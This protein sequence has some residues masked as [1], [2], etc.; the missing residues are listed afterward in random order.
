MRYSCFGVKEG[1]GEK[2]R[3]DRRSSSIS[4]QWMPYP[5]GESSA[6]LRSEKDA[7]ARRSEQFSHGIETGPVSVVTISISG[8]VS[9]AFAK[10]G[11][12]LLCTMLSEVFSPCT[13]RLRREVRQIIFQ[14]Y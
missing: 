2:Q 12:V 11:L 8:V 7:R 3:A 14:L 1:S 6:R 10:T 9:M 13:P 4:G 5:E